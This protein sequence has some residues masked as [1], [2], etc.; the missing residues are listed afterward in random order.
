MRRIEALQA[1]LA[2]AHAKNPYTEAQAEAGK[3]KA[4]TQSDLEVLR[5]P[6]MQEQVRNGGSVQVGGIHVGADPTAKLVTLGPHEAKTFQGVADGKFKSINDQLDASKTTLDSLNLGNDTGDRIALL[7]EARLALAGSGGRAFGQVMS[8]LS[9]D[10]TMASDAQKAYNWLQ[11]TP[12]L[13][14]MPPAQRNAIRESVFGRL[15]QTEQLGT[16]AA[17]QLSG[18]GPSLAPH[19]DYNSI[20]QSYTTPAMQKLQGLRQMQKDYQAQR[21]NMSA[22]P[23]SQPATAN[24]NPTTFDKLMG[25]FK[26]GDGSPA[27]T[28]Q[29]SA[30]AAPPQGQKQV[31]K[32]QYSPSRN[33]TRVMY[34]DGSSDI[35]NG[36]Q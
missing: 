26:G 23:V 16:Q 27:A 7:N 3:H 22:P 5:S 13:P 28:P 2:G 29:T 8:T 12:N 4:Q 15:D 24:P 6:E 18:M 1:F 17:A 14:K 33:Q 34:A 36:Q 31:V 35:L 25:F 19:T 9:G 32:K 30:Q 21:G 11:N 10:P 20:L